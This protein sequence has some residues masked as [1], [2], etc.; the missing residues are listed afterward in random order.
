MLFPKYFRKFGLVLSILSALLSLIIL[1]GD[2][3]PQIMGE[4]SDEISS[5][6]LIVGLILLGFSRQIVE[7]EMI[8]NLRLESLHLSL[9]VNY[10]LLIIAIIMFYDFNFLHFLL[11]NMFTT[12][13]VFN[14]RFFWVLHR[15]SSNFEK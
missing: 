7:D 11:Y 13:L 5:I 12:L 2:F 8:R 3:K 6:A 14:I 10:L 1:Y 9:Y 4:Y 15:A